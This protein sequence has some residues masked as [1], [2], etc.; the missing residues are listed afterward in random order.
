MQVRPKALLIRLCAEGFSSIASPA[1][2]VI[3]C[4]SYLCCWRTGIPDQNKCLFFPFW[5]RTM[6]CIWSLLSA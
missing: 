2:H 4:S 5:L 1:E 6:P 3:P